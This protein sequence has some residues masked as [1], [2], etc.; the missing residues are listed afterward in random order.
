MA[1]YDDGMLSYTVIQ[2][3]QMIKD[4]EPSAPGKLALEEAIKS[5]QQRD[6]LREILSSTHRRSMKMYQAD[7]LKL[8]GTVPE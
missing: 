2:I 7:F 8:K 6:T 3:L 4:K 1:D 5:L